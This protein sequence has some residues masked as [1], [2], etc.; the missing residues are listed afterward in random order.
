M[1]LILYH[2]ARPLSRGKG[3]VGVDRFLSIQCLYILKLKYRNVRHLYG[4]L[5]M[6]FACRTSGHFL[7]RLTAFSVRR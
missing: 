1:F 4:L 6:R 5:I 3:V 7:V 2:R